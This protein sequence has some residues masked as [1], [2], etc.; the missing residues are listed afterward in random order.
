MK[1]TTLYCTQGGSDKV[2]RIEPQQQG[3][4]WLICFAYGRRGST[5]TTGTKTPSPV[6]EA[7]A[8]RIH[9]R[10]LREKTAKG[11][12]VGTDQARHTQT[13]QQD[14]GIRP[15]L[16]CPVEESDLEGLLRD[17]HFVLQPKLDGKRVLLLKQDGR[18]TGIN[19]RGLECGVPLPFL[20][21]AM[22]LPG[23]FLMDGEAVGETFHV[24][25]LLEQRDK[26]LR[27]LPY[28]TR[29]VALLNLL[30][31][32]HQQAI[33]WV[34]T[35]QG[36]RMKRRLFD[37][38][39]EE[40]AEGVVFKRHT[41]PYRAGRPNS[42][43]DQLKFKFVHTASVLVTAIND[44]RSIRIGLMD[45]GRLIPSGNVSIPPNHPVPQVGQVAEVRYLYAMPG[46]GALYQPVWL[47]LRD[48]VPAS[49]CTRSQLRYKTEL[50]AA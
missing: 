6:D 49:E 13:D 43:G 15:Q 18:F 31:S 9:D 42:G 25:D 14:T 20:E 24:F 37:E 3:T 33:R 17:D 26:D 40:S 48:D 8:K 41:A 4:G 12:R 5:L 39:R 7:T 46:T 10:L 2:Y 38:L 22:R 30:A 47:G 45:R 23:N 29:L 21:A 16:L 44:K 34:Q 50:K 27:P 1:T 11:Y 28:K 32:G 36:E 35:H 19:R